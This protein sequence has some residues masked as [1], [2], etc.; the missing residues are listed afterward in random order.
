VDHLAGGMIEIV[1]Y[2]T[3]ATLPT[4]KEVDK[5]LQLSFYA[6]AATTIPTAPFGK[7]P[8][9][10]KLSLYFLDNQE[11]ISTIRTA[12]QLKEAKE[13]ILKVREEIEK[14]DFKCSGHLFCQGKCEYSLFCRVEK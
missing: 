1:D 12:E 5:N 10:V 9:K 6:L 11:K 2:K 7:R 3:G 4:Q 14:S 13:E 8:E